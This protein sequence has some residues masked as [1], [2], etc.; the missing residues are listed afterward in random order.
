MEDQLDVL[1]PKALA[2][3][4]DKKDYVEAVKVLEKEKKL[5]IS[6]L[7]QVFPARVVDDLRSQR[8]VPAMTHPSV[9]IFFSDIEGF[10]LISSQVPAL[11]VMKLLHELY[12]VM[13]YC[14]HLFPTYK[15]ETIG[16]AFM[17][18][19]GIF[20]DPE[21]DKDHFQHIANFAILVQACAAIVK[22]PLNGEPIRLR[23]G[24]H[25]GMVKSGCVGSKMP[26]FCLFGDT[27]NTASR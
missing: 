20:N 13:D 26:R 9:T 14:A 19:G 22:N 8:P 27:V 3:L 21:K 17:L 12:S 6:L 5:N 4:F 10:T 16:D 25:S 24:I 23:M 11:R 15:V 1:D 2:I 7:R 18:C